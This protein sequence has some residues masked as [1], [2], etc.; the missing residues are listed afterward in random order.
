MKAAQRSEDNQ[1]DKKA[2]GDGK[3]ADHLTGSEI[4]RIQAGYM[5]MI[6]QMRTKLSELDK[7]IK[8]S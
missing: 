8:P 7:Q 3:D 1:K 5:P 6:D 4:E 2:K